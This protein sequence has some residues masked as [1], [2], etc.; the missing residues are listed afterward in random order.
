MATERLR[1]RSCAPARCLRVQSLLPILVGLAVLVG[2]VQVCPAVEQEGQAS[3]DADWPMYNRDVSG[4][5]HNPAESVLNSKN[6]DRLTEL[7]RFPAADSDTKIGVIHATP[8]VVDG[9]AYFGTATDAAFYKISPT[10]E[11]VWR[12]RNSAYR[13][14]LNAIPAGTTAITDKLRFQSQEGGVLGSALVSDGVVYFGD[15]GGWLV[16]LDCE[17]GKER[18]KLNTRAAEFP[19]ANEGNLM[20]ASPILADGRIVIGGGTLEQLI[21]GSAFYRGSQGRGFVIAVEPQ[22]GR[23]LW[24]YDV[25]PKP[26]R[27]DPPITVVDARG[28]HTWDFGPA[29]SSVWS[30]PSYDAETGTI[31]FGTDVNTAPR[32]PT[33]DNPSFATKESCAVIAVDVR[34]GTEKWIAQI[35]PDDMW[36]NSMR[37]YD[38]ESGRYKDLS[39]GDTPKLYRIP[40]DGKATTVVGVGCKNGGFYVLRAD[41]GQIVQHT[42]IYSGPPNYPLTP[43]P[44]PRMLALPSPIGGLQSG[45]A[46]DGRTIFTN[47]I[48]A[49][50]MGTLE[51]GAARPPTGGRVVALSLDLQ[52]E[53]WRHD[54]PKIAEIGGPAPIPVYK[55]VGDPMASGL[56][57]AGGVV[58]GTT[59]SSGRLLAIDAHTGSL[60][61]EISIGPT[62][63]GPSVSRGRVY[64]GTGNT[65]FSPYPQESYFPK[66]YNGQLIC[67][68]LPKDET[69]GV[70]E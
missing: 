33:P 27:L 12:Y 16:A 1:I 37:A 19:D 49:I 40:I 47:G 22:S 35:N 70:N 2:G 59:A 64:V 65:L 57:I 53:K 46:T 28:K 30:T 7:W 15:L 61:K 32:R 20:I 42:P 58:Y 69:A 63:C 60:L 25:G 67:F 39:I 43:Q 29:T 4:S 13:G 18:W 48:D 14:I 26:Q 41:N 31:F 21:A 44:D 54:R 36:T 62:W 9:H 17:T 50:Q 51:S 24:K 68:G 8:A 34:T 3:S 56:A 11:L 23:L 55:N 38:P 5:R 10:G 45:C 52:H 6:A 66:K